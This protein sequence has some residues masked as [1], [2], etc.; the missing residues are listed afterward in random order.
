M[1]IHARTRFEEALE[2]TLE[3]ALTEK[4][5]LFQRFCSATTSAK[6]RINAL[7][8]VIEALEAEKDELENEKYDLIAE[9]AQLRIL[10]SRAGRD[11]TCGVPDDDSLDFLPDPRWAA[12]LRE[13]PDM[14]RRA[15][16]E[17][18]AGILRAAT[19]KSRNKR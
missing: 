2:K 10:L 17:R 5:L 6:A 16:A 4:A 7:E 1:A 19:R 15:L 18:T 11:Y 3:E 13:S 8:A 14:P 9:N 12:V